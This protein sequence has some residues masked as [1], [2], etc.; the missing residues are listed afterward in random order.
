MSQARAS[1]NGFGKAKKGSFGNKKIHYS[2]GYKSP[3]MNGGWS[4]GSDS[5][6]GS[7]GMRS[8]GIDWTNVLGFEPS[9]V[10]KGGSA[11]EYDHWAG[12]FKFDDVSAGVWSMIAPPSVTIQTISQAINHKSGDL[13]IAEAMGSLVEDIFARL[14]PCQPNNT[15]VRQYKDDLMEDLQLLMQTKIWRFADKYRHHR[16]MGEQEVRH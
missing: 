3:R 12:E 9:K 8:T 11:L 16:G 6:G 14:V 13:T 4:S 7:A 10:L 2:N 1:N 5:N 15:S